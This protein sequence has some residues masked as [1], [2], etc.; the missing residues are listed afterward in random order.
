MKKLMMF[1]V[2]ISSPV[3][4]DDW[5]C[6]TQASVA[7]G[8]NAMLACGMADASTE[9]QARLKAYTAALT[10]FR[11]VC[12]ASDEC[13]GRA[14][15]TKPARTECS[16]YE[17]GFRCYRAVSVTI[18]EREKDLDAEIKKRE[19]ALAAVQTR[20]IQSEKIAAV[21]T[22]LR[23]AQPNP[24]YW[25]LGLG[26][27][28]NGARFH[29][30]DTVQVGYGGSLKRCF[31]D[32]ICLGTSL[33]TGKLLVDS[34]YV[35]NFVGTSTMVSLLITSRVYIQGTAGVEYKWNPSRTEIGGVG[36]ASLGYEVVKIETVSLSLEGGVK[37]N[38]DHGVS[39]IAGAF[40]NFKF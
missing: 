14:I 35:G 10:E 9:S 13:K 38:P 20:K 36:T 7:M 33:M 30:A 4:A 24:S 23:L 22:Q 8:P 27:T 25:S 18:S 29:G 6:H 19:T 37:V 17:G 12:D 16:S 28:V 31:S 40:F 21:D 1:L 11:Q 2:L 34:E 39:P 5:V 15:E 32:V 3:M 26:L